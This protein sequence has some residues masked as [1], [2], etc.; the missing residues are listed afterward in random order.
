MVMGDDVDRLIQSLQAPQIEVS[1]K[2]QIVTE[3]KDKVEFSNIETYQEFLH[4]FFPIAEQLLKFSTPS[5]DFQ[6]WK[7][8]K[9]AIV[10][11]FLHIPHN[12]SL[13][14]FAVPLQRICLFLLRTTTDDI[15]VPCIRLLFDLYRNFR[16]SLG[17]YVEEVVDFMVQMYT[18]VGNLASTYFLNRQTFEKSHMDAM[19][20]SRS[21]AFSIQRSLKSTESFRVLVECPLIFVYLVQVYSE[22]AKRFLSSVINAMFKAVLVE[23]TEPQDTTMKPLFYDFIACQVKIISF[24][25][26]LMR[27][28]H[29]YLQSLDKSLAPVIVSLLRRCPSECIQSRKE[30]LVATRHILGTSLR[31][32]FTT[33]LENLIDE[34]TLLGT[35]ESVSDV[36]KSL[37][38]SF[39]A[40]LVHLMRQELSVEIVKKIVVIFCKNLV[41]NTLSLP[42][43]CTSA[44]LLA[45]LVDTIRHRVEMPTVRKSLFIRVMIAFLERFQ[46]IQ[47]LAGSL[48]KNMESLDHLN[49]EKVSSKDQQSNSSCGDRIEELE[50]CI[51]TAMTEFSKEFSGNGDRILRTVD[52]SCIE[53]EEMHQRQVEKDI[54]DFKI[55]LKTMIQG[56]RSILWNIQVL[57]ISN[58]ELGTHA[59]Q[60]RP[61]SN[62]VSDPKYPI[63]T[64]WKRLTEEEC[65]IFLQFLDYGCQCLSIVRNGK[66]IDEKEERELVNQFA[67]IFTELD[68][69]SFQDIFS[70]CVGHLCLHLI[71]QPFVLQ[72]FQHLIASQQ[73][74][75]YC[76]NIL[77][78]YLT[79]NLHLLDDTSSVSSSDTAATSSEGGK[80]NGESN[81]N[82]SAYL[83]VFKTLF[84]SI[85]LFSEN[86]A[87]VRPY[88]FVIVKGS[89][90]RAKESSNPQ[91]YF[92]LLRAFFKSLTGG[93]FEL[94]YKDM[95]PLLRV[96]LQ[97]F[98]YFLESGCYDE[99]R[100][101]LIELCLT[102][103]ARPSSILPHLSLHMK[104]LLFALQSE[105]TEIILLG[106]RTLEFWI[107]MLHP[108]YL[109]GVLEPLQPHLL[110]CLWSG[111]YQHSSHLASCFVKVLGKLG[112]NSRKFGSNSLSFVLEQ[113][114]KDKPVWLH[115]RNNL[116]LASMN[117]NIAELMDWCLQV[118][119]DKHSME[120]LQVDACT[121]NSLELK[122]SVFEM[123][124]SMILFFVPHEKDTQVRLTNHI[125]KW[126]SSLQSTQLSQVNFEKRIEMFSRVGLYEFQEKR[127]STFV[128]LFETILLLS[129]DIQLNDTLSQE[130]RTLVQ[131]L[132][133]FCSFQWLLV[134]EQ[135]TQD[136]SVQNFEE[137]L[138]PLLAGFNLLTR[139]NSKNVESAFSFIL[140][141]FQ[142][143]IDCM[144]EKHLSI[145]PIL[146]FSLS[147]F[148][149]FC[150]SKKLLLKKVSLKGIV[151]C[152]Q[153]IDGNLLLKPYSNVFL[154]HVLRSTFFIVADSEDLFVHLKEEIERLV[155][156]LVSKVIVDPL[157]WKNGSFPLELYHIFSME[158]CSP[159]V[160][161]RNLSKQLMSRISEALEMPLVEVFRPSLDQ[162]LKTIL[163]RP[164]RFLPFGRQVG[165]I[166]AACFLMDMGIFTPSM[167]SIGIADQS[168]N[169]QE[170]G[171]DTVGEM[172]GRRKGEEQDT[173]SAQNALE[174]RAFSDSVLAIADDATHNRLVEAED[175]ALYKL[176]DNKLTDQG[177]VRLI[178]PL[179]LSC[180]QWIKKLIG[181]VE[182]SFRSIVAAGETDYFKIW[183][184]NT[185]SSETLS[186]IN[187]ILFQSLES[188]ND[189]LVQSSTESLQLLIYQQCLQKSDLHT[190]LKPLL[191]AFGDSNKLTVRCLQGLE[192]V[193]GLFSN[194]FNRTIIEKLLE[195]LKVFTEMNM[196]SAES[197]VDWR[198]PIRIVRIF[199]K[200]PSVVVSY[201]EVLF[202]LVLQLED[203]YGISLSQDAKLL[204][205]PSS[206]SC[207]PFRVPLLSFSNAYPKETIDCLLTMIGNNRFR[208][209][210]VV[211]MEATEAEPL[212][213]SLMENF[214]HYMDNLIFEGLASVSLSSLM[215]GIPMIRVIGKYKPEFFKEN[216]L[217]YEILSKLWQVFFVNPLFPEDHLSDVEYFDVC[218]QL[219][220]TLIL[221]YSQNTSQVDILFLLFS[222][223]GP[224]RCLFDFSFVRRF[225]ENSEME[226]GITIP[227]MDVLSHLI[228]H[229]TKGSF[230]LYVFSSCL[231]LYIIPNLERMFR[232]SPHSVEIPK[233]LLDALVRHL[234]DNASEK[235]ND[236][237]FSCELLKLSTLL[238]MFIPNDLLDYRKELIKFGWDHLKKE[239]S[240]S[241]YWA[242]VNI[243]RFFEAFQAPEK[244]ILQVF[245]A[246]LRAWQSDGR[247]LIRHA[248]SIITPVIPQRIGQESKFGKA[249]V[250][251]RYTRKS[252]YVILSVSHLF[253]PL[254]ALAL[255]KLSSS[256][257]MEYRKLLLDL[258][259][260][261]LKW[262][263][264]SQ[265][266]ERE[267]QNF[268][269][270]NSEE[271]SSSM[272]QSSSEM[273]RESND[274]AQPMEEQR[275]DMQPLESSKE[276][277]MEE[278][279]GSS[280]TN[281]KYVCDLCQKVILRLVLT[282]IEHMP[283]AKECLREC[284]GLLYLSCRLFGEFDLPSETIA[285][286]IE[287]GMRV[288]TNR[289]ME[290][291]ASRMIPNTSYA[292]STTSTTGG[293]FYQQ[294]DMREETKSSV[295]EGSPA[296]LSSSKS[297]T[298]GQ[299]NGESLSYMK[300]RMAWNIFYIGTGCQT[301]VFFK[302]RW[303]YLQSLLQSSLRASDGELVRIGTKVLR[304][305]PDVTSESAKDL[306]SD[307]V[308]MLQE[309]TKEMKG[310][311]EQSSWF[312]NV[313]MLLDAVIPLNTV[314]IGTSLHAF[315][316]RAL[317]Q[318]VRERSNSWLNDRRTMKDSLY[319]SKTQTEKNRHVESAI[320]LCIRI[321]S[322]QLPL[323]TG[324]DR[325]YLLQ[326]IVVIIDNCSNEFILKQ[327]ISCVRLWILN[328]QNEQQLDSEQYYLSTKDKVQLIGKLHHLERNEFAYGVC[329]EFYQMLLE[330][331][332]NE[333]G[334][335]QEYFSKLERAFSC[336]LWS[337]DWLVH[338]E[339]RNLFMKKEELSRHPMQVLWFIIEKKD[340][341][342][343]S[344]YFWISFAS[345]LLLESFDISS[346]DLTLSEWNI[347]NYLT[348]WNGMM[349][350]DIE[351][352]P[353]MK[354]IQ[355]LF[356][357][358][359]Q[360]D[361]SNICESFE[362]LVKYSSSAGEI[363]WNQLFGHLWKQ[364]EIQQREVLEELLCKLVSKR[365]HSFQRTMETNVVKSILL[366]ISNCENSFPRLAPE[367]LAFLGI[368]FQCQPVCLSLL[369][370]RIRQLSSLGMSQEEIDNSANTYELECL[371][372]A[373][374]AIY[375]EIQERDLYW[376]TMKTFH[377]NQKYCR[378]IFLMM[379]LECWNVAQQMSFDAMTAYHENDVSLED[380]QVASIEEAWIE[381]AKQL[382]Q[383]DVLTDF[384]RSIVNTELLHECL[385]R[386][387]DW[388]GLKEIVNKYPV[389]D[390]VQLK[391]YQIS[392]QLQE[393]KLE[394]VGYL[395]SQGYQELISRF[396]SLPRPIHLGAF[397]MLKESS[398]ILT[399]LSSFARNKVFEDSRLEKILQI[400]TAWKERLPNEWDYLSFWN[401][402]ITWRIHM[403]TVLVN[404]FQA[405]RESRTLEVPPILL[406]LGVNE[407]AWNVNTFGK[408][409]RK[410]GCTDVCLQSFQ[411]LYNFPTMSP[412]EYF[413][414]VKEQAKCCLQ[415]DSCRWTCIHQQEKN[416]LSTSLQFGLN[417]L[418]QCDLE[419]F[420]YYQQA[421]LL[422][423][424]AKFYERL[425]YLENAN[426]TFA[427]A[428]SLCSDL[429]SGWLAWGDY[430]DRVFEQSRDFTWSTAAVNCFF[431]S[432]RFGSRRAR[433]KMARIFRLLSLQFALQ[434]GHSTDKKI[435]ETN[436]PSFSSAS[437]STS[438]TTTTTTSARNA[439]NAIPHDDSLLHSR[440]EEQNRKEQEDAPSNIWEMFVQ[441]VDLLPSWLWIP[442]ITEMIPMLAL[443]KVAQAYPQ[444][445]F[446]V[447]RSFM[448]ERKGIDRP[449]KVQTLEAVN[450]PRK[451]VQALPDSAAERYAKEQKKHAEVL[452]K[453]YEELHN[454]Y[455]TGQWD[456][457]YQQA[458]MERILREAKLQAD[459]ATARAQTAW[460]SYE[461]MRFG[462]NIGASS[463]ASFSQGSRQYSTDNLSTVQSRDSPQASVSSMGVS[464]NM[465]DKQM[466]DDSSRTS[467]NMS[468]SPF[469]LA[470]SI[471]VHIVEQNH[472]LYMELERLCSELSTKLKSQPEEQLFSL[473]NVVLQRCSQVALHGQQKEITPSVRTALEE[474]SK[475]CF[476]TGLSSS[477]EFRVP[478]YLADLKETFEKELAPQTAENFP[479][480]V[481]EL[482][483]RLQRWKKIIRQRL[484][485]QPSRRH[486]ERISRYLTDSFTCATSCAVEVFGVYHGCDG[487]R[488]TE[489]FPLIDRF[490]SPVTVKNEG[491]VFSR[492]IQVLGSDG[493]VYHFIAES[494]VSTSLQRAEDRTSHLLSLFNQICFLKNAS[495]RRRRIR[496]HSLC[497]IPTGSHSRLVACHTSQTN[498]TLMEPLIEYSDSKSCELDQITEHFRNHY[499]N[500]M[501]SDASLKETL[502]QK[503]FLIHCR[504]K[505]FESVCQEQIPNNILEDW[506]TCRVGN[507]ASL[508]QFHKEFSI[509]YAVTSFIQYWLCFGC[510]KPSSIWLNGQ[511]GSVI[512][513]GLR[514]VLS[515]R[516][517]VEA[518]DA[519]PFRLTPNIV[520]WLRRFG[521]FGYFV[522]SMSLVRLALLEQQE[523]LRPLLEF[524]IREDIISFYVARQS[525]QSRFSA[526]TV[527]S[528][529]RTKTVG[530]PIWEWN[531][532]MVSEVETKLKESLDWIM[533]RRLVSTSLVQNNEKIGYL[534]IT[535]DTQYLISLAEDWTNICQM[536]ANWYPWY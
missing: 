485:Q 355:T 535:E 388:A 435:S 336:G 508:Y 222:L 173:A 94:L 490:L 497:S 458:Q 27:D 84:A 90:D 271:D 172:F 368:H 315:L 330:I 89:L 56:I 438:I 448:E 359:Q 251:A 67:Q 272:D 280:Q 417:Q 41:D 422:V 420:N 509:S 323:L 167:F 281:S 467:L 442:W 40:E 210:F 477:H 269:L 290:E 529:S 126:I 268:P 403:H 82:Q 457:Q 264:W 244:V 528:S 194:W 304:R 157:L 253:I 311:G 362:K 15:G 170:E 512:F 428:V 365:Y 511:N 238:I 132:L 507:I 154:L 310:L 51:E 339:M 379:Q 318:A 139:G 287:D 329:D 23:A 197:S 57:E 263:F 42:V 526:G 371:M 341:E 447:L 395:F 178:A 504:M 233:E 282:T 481:D 328:A 409:A 134:E 525:T 49:V 123:V 305:I 496:M 125:N 503:E 474:V 77:L 115:L 349:E 256:N 2:V 380:S 25:S 218:Q 87:V 36:V 50:D 21:N 343:Y 321:L 114:Q 63:G 200:L 120:S 242:F 292:S 11:L 390:G 187:K 416:S 459:Q 356:E 102:I 12:A 401:E 444:A 169:E 381:S 510:R 291:T 142:V 413:T 113:G 61:S 248:L 68:P 95:I 462:G 38:Y 47:E 257:M 383:W 100:N 473:I 502:S 514:T 262:E 534:S 70:V 206:V 181:L 156:F 385:W 465:E 275:F 6:E 121:R 515:S 331:F 35:S 88:I 202:K 195:H 83:S 62:L 471:M 196:Q 353:W 24:F 137:C 533:N 393:N 168:P 39:L 186:K 53:R 9:L 135:L 536:E 171:T 303:K 500:T 1:R 209:L 227:L 165:Y 378:D 410:Q 377:R 333:T 314:T 234:F 301:L 128:L 334:E 398:R 367:I 492:R 46:S 265:K 279:T 30:L 324:D 10:D 452:R 131:H 129:D 66:L 17:P 488:H 254:I 327:V 376:E 201:Q 159:S 92:R 337:R 450:H 19:E 309:E 231:R 16:S 405:M 219:V 43:Q 207:S 193:L 80:D 350:I 5:N 189:N 387:P 297:L 454:R 174:L 118:A 221:Y 7:R 204:E 101:L 276:D 79:K 424:K 273:M 351:T 75:K 456:S 164:I 225:F 99:Y 122:K 524:F 419:Q 127:K 237:G 494:S 163:A 429:S 441:Y 348:D 345:E 116:P 335:F 296:T 433:V 217:V 396:K 475:L 399:E 370:R 117:W 266:E 469:E 274:N 37:G 520:Q 166:S 103:P 45:S 470:D 179:K 140:Q 146:I 104:P 152:L 460:L 110:Q 58:A 414:K 453:R 487:E 495:T 340:W 531:E 31:G 431:Q 76:A 468:S 375:R 294:Q 259:K 404:A 144:G 246:L 211:L 316:S 105:S 320:G 342:P 73:L 278:G 400:L 29:D 216:P 48:V 466:E 394:H 230:S 145:H 499:R 190:N 213:R 295:P 319:N 322:R 236:D 130:P 522:T 52:I 493:H 443:V 317:Y 451:P 188:N 4:Q 183:T 214:V 402:L 384:S 258:F 306:L 407:S 148:C 391:I 247:T 338:K 32:S 523:W 20:E 111:V 150:Y 224:Q 245:L 34:T 521:N 307:L 112:G 147:S 260:L 69:P 293:A 203:C 437:P 464:N 97:D 347:E 208:H 283:N 161:C 93:K 229:V 180:L 241:K 85:T 3:L 527:D 198:I 430:C 408:V 106:L 346:V 212:R 8:L 284:C 363:I 369:E 418:N 136:H 252:C 91:N 133:E 361:W 300:Y 425:G 26:Y 33:E 220:K 386:L 532:E 439:T 74:S 519:V 426:Q 138:V 177:V 86:E 530:H 55:L 479:K 389:E 81:G 240:T 486:L 270:T 151:R 175:I 119:D 124:R 312:Y 243:S 160:E 446:Y 149:H 372:D 480:N 65:S 153:L 455:R 184:S 432:I 249:P 484:L 96:I 449:E 14:P 354:N 505:A 476:G 308:Y 22:V 411:Q 332:R 373:K 421:Q 286:F 352:T 344:D 59:D 472:L 288:E 326:S 382:N 141:C 406:G 434:E 277:A 412:A 298:E 18:N 72:I 13:E 483:T 440:M 360:V 250:F 461:R 239:D 176:V 299:S 205:C 109:A 357:Q 397:D 491:G 155:E 518:E 506:I 158:L 513:A 463:S 235:W 498:C 44:K 71:Q 215:V 78:S 223:F 423:L 191:S 489:S 261:L 445:I 199:S 54:S 226:Y 517:I 501:V 366:A 143:A 415:A 302:D 232:E 285:S 482:I 516:G 325:K 108:D 392:L 255:R 267:A 436:M 374:L 162:I 107:A 28:H 364:L 64:A 427:T 185:Q 358:R 182:S 228:Q 313:V 289:R 60:R 192:R 98:L 478:S